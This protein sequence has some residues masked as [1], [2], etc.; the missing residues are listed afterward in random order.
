MVLGLLRTTTLVSFLLDSCL[1]FSEQKMALLSP[2][3][4]L[5]DPN[6]MGYLEQ[7]GLY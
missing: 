4:L 2:P 5:G 7:K 3:I 1:T 6:G